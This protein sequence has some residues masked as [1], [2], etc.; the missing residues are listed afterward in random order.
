[1]KLVAT[2]PD[3]SPTEILTNGGASTGGVSAR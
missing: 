2:N 3:G 1:M